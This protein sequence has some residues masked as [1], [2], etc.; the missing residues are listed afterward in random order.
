[1][2]EYPAE[3]GPY[4]GKGVGEMVTNGPIPAIVSAINNA[5]DVR[6]TE[7]PVT[8]E[9]VLRALDEKKAQAAG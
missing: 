8:P 4:G 6:I 1:M 7:I 2:L 9:V 5:L 3:S